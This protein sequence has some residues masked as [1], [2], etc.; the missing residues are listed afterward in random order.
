ME[1]QQRK[2]LVKRNTP[3]GKYTQRFT[4]LESERKR[5]LR[6]EEKRE[7]KLESLI[8]PLNPDLSI[9]NKDTASVIH[10]KV[11]RRNNGNN[12]NIK[13]IGKTRNVAAI[14]NRRN[15]NKDIKNNVNNRMNLNNRNNE[16]QNKIKPIVQRVSQKQYESIKE[17]NRKDYI[18]CTLPMYDLG[19]LFG[20]EQQPLYKI[21]KAPKHNRKY[22]LEDEIQE[23]ITI[24]EDEYEHLENNTTF[25]KKTLAEM[26]IKG[27]KYGVERDVVYCYLIKDCGGGPVK[28]IGRRCLLKM[29]QMQEN[30]E[31]FF[32]KMKDLYEQ[33]KD[34]RRI[35]DGLFN[36]KKFETEIESLKS[37][38]KVFEEM[39]NNKNSLKR[40]REICPIE[41]LEKRKK[42]DTEEQKS[43]EELLKEMVEKRNEQ[44]KKMEEMEEEFIQ[45]NP[46]IDAFANFSDFH[47]IQITD[48][49]VKDEEQ[50][51]FMYHMKKIIEKSK[52]DLDDI[53]NEYQCDFDLSISDQTIA[54]SI[55]TDYIVF[56]TKEFPEEVFEFVNNTVEYY[57][58][59]KKELN[60][61]K[62]QYSIAKEKENVLRKQFD[63]SKKKY[64]VFK[65]KYEE[66][67]E[68]ER[69]KEE[70]MKK[71]QRTIERKKEFTNV[72]EFFDDYEK[73][74]KEMA[75]KNK[76]DP[77]YET[78]RLELVELDKQMK[79]LKCDKLL[80]RINFI[81]NEIKDIHWEELTPEAI[82]KQKK[83][84][85][86][87][88]FKNHQTLS[89]YIRWKQFFK[90]E[91]YQ[92]ATIKRMKDLKN[93]VGVFFNKHIVDLVNKKEEDKKQN[94][95]TSPDY[96]SSKGKDVNEFTLQ[97]DCYIIHNNLT[98]K[99]FTKLSNSLNEAMS[100]IEGD[101]NHS[102]YSY[103]INC[104]SFE[105]RTAYVD[106]SK[107]LKDFYTK[108]NN[109]LTGDLLEN[110][111]NQ[112]LYILRDL[113]QVYVDERLKVLDE[114]ARKREELEKDMKVKERE[115]KEHEEI[116]EEDREI[117]MEEEIYQKVE[118]NPSEMSDDDSFF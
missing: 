56:F 12:F 64:D 72:L 115:R 89:E 110:N 18:V 46:M 21:Q 106:R 65:K 16:T 33:R 37:Q 94:I 2:I 3:K 116:R 69:K 73:K 78:L 83:K 70:E 105:A 79:D 7:M 68:I 104:D 60:E 99:D 14:K 86:V 57:N 81:E 80:S 84:L 61:K 90:F 76:K 26:V 1:S 114:E 42:I 32:K 15:N 5:K 36:L 113:R 38:V 102:K 58:D 45:S 8:Q 98:R 66:L 40:R 77:E 95:I 88:A 59:L 13:Q 111:H 43:L 48:E 67:K 87:I 19:E 20:I 34:S 4:A 6:E 96:Y 108:Y 118:Y 55:S 75:E 117:Q 47:L 31:E 50:L 44:I 109:K 97:Q 112:L 23:E 82:E 27:K 11:E 10:K 62:E 92:Q 71:K 53:L 63:E 29:K 22:T 107:V 25:V 52:N 85:S 35:S 9:L 30:E 39:K 41:S 101:K 93:V 49:E 54:S 91:K 24:L 74:K 100:R 17:E 103:Y 28:N 51:T